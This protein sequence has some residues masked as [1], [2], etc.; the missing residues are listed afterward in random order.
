MRC[1]AYLDV[2]L[3]RAAG[4]ARTAAAN[5]A[6]DTPTSYH[7]VRF[8][9]QLH[10][11]RA[12]HASPGLSE[13]HTQCSSSR[14]RCRFAAA[15]LQLTADP[16]HLLAPASPL[17]ECLNFSCAFVHPRMTA[18]YPTPFLAPST[19]ASALSFPFSLA[20]DYTQSTLCAAPDRPR[21]RAASE[22]HD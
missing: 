20:S 12:V 15:R 14:S 8:A 1:E 16:P 4:R 19:I 21:V 5:G 17:S 6:G 10:A 13:D 7:Y 18:N 11:P 9:A 2:Y 22:R 3:T